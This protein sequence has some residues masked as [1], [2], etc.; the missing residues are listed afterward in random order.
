MPIKT[1]WDKDTI[2]EWAVALKRKI[3]ELCYL[4]D[5]KDFDSLFLALPVKHNL[6][7]FIIPRDG[8]FSAKCTML[9]GLGYAVYRPKDNIEAADYILEYING[10]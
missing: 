8:K 6:G 3:P 9:R 7:L 4:I 2:K 1:T 10:L 5:V